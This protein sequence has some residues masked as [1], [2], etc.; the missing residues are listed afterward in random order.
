VGGIISRG[1]VGVEMWCF[2]K[3]LC[4][5]LDFMFGGIN[6]CCC[7]NSCIYFL[8]SF[9]GATVGSPLRGYLASKNRWKEDEKGGDEGRGLESRQRTAG[10]QQ[11]GRRHLGVVPT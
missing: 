5:V 1:R 10:K 4:S 7:I 3:R 2:C 6:R 9:C 8:F 11:R